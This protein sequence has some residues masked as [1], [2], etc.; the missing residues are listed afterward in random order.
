MT[1]FCALSFSPFYRVCQR[2]CVWFFILFSSVFTSSIMS[3]AGI[4]ASHLVAA[5]QYRSIK[6]TT[7][8]VAKAEE[9]ARALLLRVPLEEIEAVQQDPGKGNW[10]V[11]FKTIT[12]AERLAE[13]GFTLLNEHISPVLYNKRLITATVAF[14]PPGTTPTDI[15]AVLQEYAQVKQV[16]PIFLRDFPSI[17]SGKFRVVLQ[18]NG[19]GTPEEVLPSFITLHGRRASLFFSGRISR[20]PYCNSADH[21]GRDCPHRGQPR[22]FSCNVLGHVRANCPDLAAQSTATSVAL[23]V[24]ENPE[25][26]QTSSPPL[27]SAE[28]STAEPAAAASQDLFEEN[29]PTMDKDSTAQSDPPSENSAV[30][31]SEEEEPSERPRSR[32]PINRAEQREK[33][34]QQSKKKKDRKKHK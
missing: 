18:L 4:T 2:S 34:G 10:T 33:N 5:I 27:P 20:C 8:P 25:P 3:F 6:F 16:H 22:C 13:K 28:E 9:I 21:L 29:S 17:K 19:E 30:E 11:I 31:N 7:L 24:V 26:A 15:Q 12:A 23:S 1:S 14:A 32:S